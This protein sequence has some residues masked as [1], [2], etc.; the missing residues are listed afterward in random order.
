MINYSYHA[1]YI[2][3]FKQINFLKTILFAYL[4]V[5]V[6]ESGGGRGISRLPAEHRARYQA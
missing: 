1:V 3:Y 4:C 6:R 2:S 5:C